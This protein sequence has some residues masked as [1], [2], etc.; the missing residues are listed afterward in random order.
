LSQEDYKK[1]RK[2]Q[3]QQMSMVDLI[4]MGIIIF[5]TQNPKTRYFGHKETK[6]L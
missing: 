2:G 1:K 3:S 5:V 6:P 4:K